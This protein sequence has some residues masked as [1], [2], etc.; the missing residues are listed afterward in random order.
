MTHIT[1]WSHPRQSDQDFAPSRYEKLFT[2]I[3][4]TDRNITPANAH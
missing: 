3:S 4:A 2:H 1:S